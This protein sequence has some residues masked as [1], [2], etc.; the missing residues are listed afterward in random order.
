[1]Q[2]QIEYV[3]DTETG[4]LSKWYVSSNHRSL[5]CD[6]F[7]NLHL[8]ENARALYDGERYFRDVPKDVL[9]WLLYIVIPEMLA[10]SGIKNI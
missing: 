6:H 9:S 2:R 3:Y 8:R 7:R 4:I 10:K 5:F 1:M